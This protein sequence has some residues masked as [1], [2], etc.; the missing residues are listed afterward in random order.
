MRDGA[1]I[2]LGAG[3]YI[4]TPGA[5]ALT[6]REAKF[7]AD[8]AIVAAGATAWQIAGQQVEESLRA[9]GVDFLFH[10]FS[11][12][13]SETTVGAIVRDA[14]SFGARLIIGVGGGKCMDTV[15]LAADCLGVRV[16]TVPTSAATCACYAT[17]CIKYDDTGTPD[18]NEYCRQPVAAVLVDT[19]LLARRC[20]ARM[21]AAGVADAMAKYPEIDFSIRFVKGWDITIMPVSALQVAKSNTDKY[22]A[23]A[24]NAV[25]QVADGTLTPVVDDIIFTNLALTGLTSQLSSGSKQLA[26]AHG[27]YDAV[28]KL[29]KPQ[30][31]RLLHGEIVSCGI[32]VQLAVNGYSEEYIEKNVRFLELIGTPMQFSQLGIEPTEENLEQILAF[33]FDNVG[34]DEPALQEKIRKNFARVMK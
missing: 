5:A 33:I 31:A 34:I 6:G 18:C 11:G 23:D 19:D 20:P 7:F 27:L 17:V 32:P 14:E 13:C 24:A 22:F 28:S 21:L 2:I 10:P 4:Q 16:I 8:R 3:R 9:N 29:F 25:L 26:V 30:R 12:F 15:K 1:Q